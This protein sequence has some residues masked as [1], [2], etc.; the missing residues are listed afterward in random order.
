ME[1]FYETYK[2]LLLELSYDETLKRMDDSKFMRLITGKESIEDMSPLK[3]ASY[4]S[5]KSTI[6][7]SVPR[8]NPDEG[9]A[10][11]EKEKA[12]ALNWIIT[13][14]VRDSP[15]YPENRSFIRTPS[16]QGLGRTG[17]DFLRRQLELF[18]QIKQDNMDRLL[19]KKAIELY[20]SFEEFVDSIEEIA[21][22]FREYRAQKREKSAKSE[23]QL[24]VYENNTWEIYFP[25]THGA[26]CKLGSSHWCTASSDPGYYKRYAEEDQLIIFSNKKNP[27]EKYQFHF[28]TGHFTDADNVELNQDDKFYYLNYILY[29]AV[30][31]TEYEK[32]LSEVALEEINR[33]YLF[34]DVIEVD[35]DHVLI[36]RGEE[37]GKGFSKAIINTDTFKQ[38]NPYSPLAMIR[39]SDT[40]GIK[41]RVYILQNADIRRMIWST[42]K[43][44]KIEQISITDKDGDSIDYSNDVNNTF[45]NIAYFNTF[46]D[47]PESERPEKGDKNYFAKLSTF[48]NAEAQAKMVPQEEVYEYKKYTDFGIEGIKDRV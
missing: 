3:K 2:F 13:R 34:S 1:T 8:D 44:N 29:K 15:E 31:N 7:K 33:L 9:I 5:L 47:V 38:E 6:I 23:D 16:N 24:K 39:Y 19:P 10:F 14:I 17:A 36:T 40:P 30:K 21:P 18:Y 45:Y 25:Q 26:A 22:K 35:N 4:T 46:K 42:D 43:N 48:R 12:N 32:Y 27:E 41:R 28:S 11:S 20:G 37:G